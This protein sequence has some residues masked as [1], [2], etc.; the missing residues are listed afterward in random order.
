MPKPPHC[1]ARHGSPKAR[2]PRCPFGC[3]HPPARASLAPAG[4]AAGPGLPPG[5]SPGLFALLCQ[6]VLRSQDR[7][8]PTE[9]CNEDSTLGT[10]VL[11][12]PIPEHPEPWLAHPILSQSSARLGQDSPSTLPCIAPHS[13]TKLVISSWNI[14]RL[15]RRDCP[16]VNPGLLFPVTVMSLVCLE[17]FFRFICSI[18][19][20]KI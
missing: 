11:S 9:L 17:R 6:A 12:P 3:P 2:A 4:R 5:L 18:I 16:F 10:P 7:D 19:Y 13:S 15:L 20:P 14:I 8:N 1:T